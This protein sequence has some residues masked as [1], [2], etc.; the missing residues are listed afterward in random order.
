MVSR[1]FEQLLVALEGVRPTRDSG[2][3]KTRF[4]MVVSGTVPSLMSTE[5]R[6]TWD[7]TAGD[8]KMRKRSAKNEDIIFR[9]RDIRHKGSE[10]VVIYGLWYCTK[11]CLPIVCCRPGW[12][13][14][15]VWK[16]AERMGRE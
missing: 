7:Y 13:R 15:P 12:I 10:I 1:L 6:L 8:G 5:W 3:Q 9:D 14:T 11:T 2:D 16:I 4:P